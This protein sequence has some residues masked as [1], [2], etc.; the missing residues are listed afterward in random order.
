MIKAVVIC[1]IYI[2]L[3][4]VGMS[5]IKYANQTYFKN[6]IMVFGISV[7]PILILGFFLYGLSFLTFTLFVSRLQISIAIPVVSGIY[8]GLT[9]IVGHFVFNETISLDAAPSGLAPRARGL[10]RAPLRPWPSAP[11]YVML[12]SQ[13]L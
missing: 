4:L 2:L 8:C 12:L 7:S 13:H 6:S 11:S 5:L 9:V 10:P 3:T 1:S